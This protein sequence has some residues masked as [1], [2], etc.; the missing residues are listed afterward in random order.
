MK[1]VRAI[2]LMS[3]GL[4]STLSAKIVKEQGVEVYGVNFYTGFCI[5]ET[6]RRLGCPVPNDAIKAGANIGV[7]VDIIDV[8]HEY[9]DI[10]LN[11]SYGYGANA[12][13]CLDCRIFM[14]KKA[15]EIMRKKGAEFIITGEV[16]GQRPMSQ[17]RHQLRKIEKETGLE[18]L[19]LRPL[20]ALLLPS[21]IPEE[22]GWVKRGLLFGIR[23]RSRKAQMELAERFGVKEYPQPAGG[24][25]FLTDETYARR[26]FDFLRNK[27]K[28]KF[29]R[30]EA[31]LLAFGRHLR[32]DKKTKVIVGRNK[33]ENDVLENVAGKK[34]KLIPVDVK[35]PVVIVD[36]E[37]DRERLLIAGGVLG[38]Y[39]DG[40]NLPLIRFKV[41]YPDRREEIMEVSPLSPEITERMM[42]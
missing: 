16:V 26:F 5:T 28:E 21:T 7:S 20:S 39:S 4:D 11:P 1:D 36:G 8:S 25:C 31:I 40:K 3:G 42:I 19:I 37:A 23:G 9:M 41:I 32:I 35:G 27:E 14:L 6:K 30:E 12:N 2:A 22:K 33:D 18:R 29:T 38:R 10:L 17:Q 13:P 24:C 15:K 34:V